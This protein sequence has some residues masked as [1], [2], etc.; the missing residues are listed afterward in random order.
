MEIKNLEQF[1]IDALLK[2]LLIGVSLILISNLIPYPEDKI[3]I[4]INLII[5]TASIL[6]YSFRYKYP[7][8]IALLFASK[9][10]SISIY[11]RL[12]DTTSIFSFITLLIGGIIISV[13]LKG[14]ILGLMHIIALVVINTIFLIDEYHFFRT[15]ISLSALYFIVTFTVGVMKNGYD[16]INL[17]LQKANALLREKAA[18]VKT[19]NVEINRVN[20]ELNSNNKRLEDLV[21]ERTASLDRQLKLFGN[22]IENMPGAVLRYRL[23]K[24]GRD[25]LVFISDKAEELWEIPKED[26]LKNIGLHWEIAFKEDIPLMQR[27]ISISAEEMTLWRHQWRIHTKSGKVK[28][29][30]GAAVPEKKSDGAIEWDTLILDITERKEAEE[31]LKVSELRLNSIIEST[32]DFIALFDRHHRLLKWNSSYEKVVL[33]NRNVVSKEGV[34]ILEVLPENETQTFWKPLFDRAYEGEFVKENLKFNIDENNVQYLD[35]RLYPVYRENEIIGVTQFTKDITQEKTN[36]LQRL[37]NEEKLSY[38]IKSL[39][40]V[41]WAIDGQGNFTY[42]RGKGLERLGLKD[43]EALGENIYKL[44]D[45]YPQILNTVKKSIELKK[46]LDMEVDMGNTVFKTFVRPVD[47]N[48]EEN[49]IIGVSL[50]ITD[51]LK[52]KKN[53]EISESYLESIIDNTKYSVWAIDKQLNITLMNKSMKHYFETT[54]GYVPQKGES[55]FLGVEASHKTVWEAIYTKALNGES[56]NFEYE[57]KDRFFEVVLNPI[58]INND[59]EGVSV[60]SKDITKRK[61]AV[62]RLK[63]RNSF[64]DNILATVPALVYIHNLDK[65]KTVYLNDPNFGALK[66]DGS[67]SGFEE[68]PLLDLCHEEDVFKLESYYKERESG[69]DKLPS[70]LLL[71][72]E[73]VKGEWRWTMVR[74]VLLQH[75]KQ[76]KEYL[77]IAIDIHS[78]FK[79]EEELRAKSAEIIETT[80]Q[81]A[82]YKLMAFRS[83]MNPH[84]LFNS[85]NS[86]QYF[87]ALNQREEALS[88]LSLFSKLI[89][90]IISSS[91][92]GKILLKEEI[93]TI[94]N[95]VKLEQTRFENKFDFLCEIDPKLDV[96]LV[97]IPS[98]LIQPFIENAIIHGLAGITEKGKI[99]IIMKKAVD[100]MHCEITDNGIGREAAKKLRALKPKEHQSVG[101][102]LTKERL[103]IINKSHPVSMEI[104]DLQDEAGQAIGTKVILF[105]KI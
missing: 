102:M 92:T 47:N 94:E 35:F 3:A 73:N 16:K 90:K 9:F 69:N 91:V 101:V 40:V 14:K 54:F 45:Q 6:S 19:Q 63:E 62:E 12:I 4:S 68:Q 34:D 31:K 11:I 48:E 60:F 5:I 50:D 28:W 105:I 88:Y 56:M 23:D 64:I 18:E 99:S 100:Y 96:N 95:Y 85:L 103:E 77:G 52:T 32:S 43:D 74:E 89:R 1:F 8:L 98:L 10:I 87:I 42:S 33:Q 53:L 58:N 21:R 55:A 25:S 70:E 17:K 39:P 79:K 65:N 59:I 46:T 57:I 75:S 66:E 83:V 26:A 37:E 61:N 30:E 2:I 86:I 51:T 81:M 80:K 27:S 104:I 82:N 15:A 97:E 44:Y 36:E 22:I 38:I 78:L 72:L 13:F 67:N 24:D 76:G 93:E 71:R 84:F 29:L 49:G 20:E 41:V 7:T